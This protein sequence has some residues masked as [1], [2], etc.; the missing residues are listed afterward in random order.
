M[1]LLHAP[2]TGMLLRH[3]HI[4]ESLVNYTHHSILS[5]TAI[6]SDSD[7]VGNW[8]VIFGGNDGSKCFN[9]VHV[10]EETSEKKWVWSHPKCKGDAPSPRTGHTAI[11]LNDGSTILVY[12]GWDP[13][14]ED[15]NGEDLIFGD[16]YLLDTKTWM[17]RKGPKPRYE[18][19]AKGNASNGGVGRVGHSAVLAGFYSALA[20]GGRVPENKFVD[21]FQS[22]A[23]PL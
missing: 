10:M 3:V 6:R 15:E 13:N 22:L 23:V 1:H 7:D 11:L 2:T 18:K 16:S 20:F 14:T 12:G 17:W 19:S 9:G 21:D 5:A 4:H 8:V